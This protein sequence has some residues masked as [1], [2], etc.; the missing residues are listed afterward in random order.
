MYDPDPF[1]PGELAEEQRTGYFTLVQGA[2]ASGYLDGG[3]YVKVT[4]PADD[5]HSKSRNFCKKCR[6]KLSNCTGGY[7]FVDMSDP[8]DPVVFTMTENFKLR[9]YEIVINTAEETREITVTGQK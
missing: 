7:A 9:C 3:N 8:N 2:G 6:S 4:I 5:A 1:R